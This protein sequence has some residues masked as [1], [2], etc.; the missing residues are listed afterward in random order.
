MTTAA[1]ELGFRGGFVGV[2]VFFVISGYLITSIQ[3]CALSEGRSSLQAFWTRRV[4]RLFPAS[5]CMLA[6]TLFAGTF[7]F[8][9]SLYME[10]LG[11]AD[12]TLL[13]YANFW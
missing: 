1:Q 11:Q 4:R 13:I 3:L 5:A 7:V 8:L 10:L 2:D 9:P 6:G 12:A